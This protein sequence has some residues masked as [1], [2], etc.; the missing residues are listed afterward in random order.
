M[1]INI[2]TSHRF[3]LLDLARELEKQGHDVT[4]YS[5]VPKKRAISFGL[6]KK[7]CHSYLWFI[8]PFLFLQ[9]CFPRN[10]HILYMRNI[11]IDFYLRLFM[12]P[13]DIYIALGTVYKRSFI[14]AKKKYK[15]ITIVE[16]GSK[17][18]DA[19]QAILK[20]IGI[21]LNKDYFNKRSKEGYS[22]ADYIAISSEHVKQSFLEYG[23]PEYKLIQNPYGVNLETFAPTKL[24]SN[25]EIF[26]IIMV[27]GWS[28][29][30][31]CDLLIDLCSQYEYSLL[32]VGSIVDI[33][34]PNKKGMKHI[35]AVNQ[36]ELPLYYAQAKIFVLPSREE[37]LAMVQPQA[38]ACGLP[39]VCSQ[40]T[41][42]R[43]LKQFLEEKKWVIEMKE[44]SIKELKKCVDQ[45]LEL[46]KEQKGKR[47]YAKEA[48]HNLTW[49]AYGKRYNENILELYEKKRIY[50]ID[51]MRCL[52][53]LNL[54]I[55]YLL[56]PS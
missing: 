14:T 44:Y 43:D 34:F 12:K 9:K 46:V 42:G 24:E 35:P 2:A 4:F 27:G 11:L 52:L 5:F 1:K 16:W 19:Q 49:E 39:I 29:R 23:I 8:A 31:G 53:N 10:Q 54:N 7:C 37:G 45:A 15:A 51:T 18:I 22:L 25:N 30:K 48:I 38:L 20:E 6:S 13:C 26:D 32:H 17:H 36:S 28:Y 40:H 56:N 33:E 21:R 41:G 55:T 3:H 47:E 50:S